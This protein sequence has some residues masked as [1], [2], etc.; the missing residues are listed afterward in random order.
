MVQVFN[1][2][3]N[4][5]SYASPNTAADAN[6]GKIMDGSGTLGPRIGHLGARFTF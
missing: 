1:R 6:L 4:R 3:S 2:H 5:H